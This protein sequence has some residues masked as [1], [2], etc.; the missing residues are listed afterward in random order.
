MIFQLA[1]LNLVKCRKERKQPCKLLVQEAQ[2][3]IFQ[4][5]DLLVN[6]RPVAMFRVHNGQPA[7]QPLDFLFLALNSLLPDGHI[8]S[9]QDFLPANGLAVGQIFLE[10]AA[11]FLERCQLRFI[12]ELVLPDISRT[13][14]SL[15]EILVFGL[16][17][18]IGGDH[19]SITILTIGMY[20]LLGEVLVLEFLP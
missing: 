5:L 19:R 14:I 9:N 13:N 8:I 3:D 10:Y 18:F 12:L 6:C 20:F 4:S 1:F 16:I 2:S 17:G 11:Q 7:L 15:L